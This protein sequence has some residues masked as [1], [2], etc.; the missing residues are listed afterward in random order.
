[1]KKQD[2]FIRM[3]DGTKALVTGYTYQLGAVRIGVTR[4]A[5]DGHDLGAWSTTELFTGACITFGQ[6]TMKQAV[7][8][9]REKFLD[10]VEKGVVCAMEHGKEDTNPGL[11]PQYTVWTVHTRKTA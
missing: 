8:D 6:N 7:N 10:R 1:M 3:T 2:F 4:E 9:V 11:V 5:I